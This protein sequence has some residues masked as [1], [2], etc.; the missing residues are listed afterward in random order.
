LAAFA[1]ALSIEPEHRLASLNQFITFV[2]LGRAEQATSSAKRL[3][4]RHGNDPAILDNIAHWHAVEGRWEQAAELFAREL[5][6][7]RALP[8]ADEALGEC[9]KQLGEVTSEPESE[10]VGG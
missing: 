7:G 4:E 2:L 3:V 6:T 5:E 8:G 10:A 9:L 1:R